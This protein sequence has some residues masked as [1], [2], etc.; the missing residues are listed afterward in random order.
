VMPLFM[1]LQVHSNHGHRHLGLGGF[2]NLLVARWL[3][4]YLSW[5]HPHS[6]RHSLNIVGALATTL[7]VK[8]PM[9]GELVFV[10]PWARVWI[11]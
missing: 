2:G 1:A 9:I 7:A 10:Q 8:A 3:A 6:H 11:L 5:A 4:L